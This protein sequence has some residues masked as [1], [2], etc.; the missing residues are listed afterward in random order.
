MNETDCFF[1]FCQKSVEKAWWENHELEFF[2]IVS[3]CE[4]DFF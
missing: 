2:K 4:K 3:W 1:C